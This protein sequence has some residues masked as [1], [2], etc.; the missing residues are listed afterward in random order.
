M[1]PERRHIPEWARRERES[2]LSWIQENLDVFEVAARIA[3]EESGRGAIVVD[4]TVQPLAHGGH[5]FAYF[6][7][8]QIEE[9]ED[10]DIKRMV[11]KYDPQQEFVLVLLKEKD[12]TSTYRV[13]PARGS[14]QESN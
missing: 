14:S 9:D 8:A 3:Y 5:P 7:Q 1:S 10:E 11:R 4:T 12:R 2:D 6:S 13:R